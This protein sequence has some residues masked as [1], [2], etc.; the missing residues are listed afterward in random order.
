MFEF[1]EQH[2]KLILAL[3]IAVVLGMT[4]ILIFLTV[5][6]QPATN[7]TETVNE[8][9]YS[10][11]QEDISQQ[12]Q[13]LMLLGKIVTEGYGTYSK[14]DY[15]G[16]LDV[17]NQATEQF[18]ATVQQQ[19]NTMPATKNVSTVVDAE[20]IKLENT[21]SSSATVRMRGISTEAGKQQSITSTVNL[22][23]EGEYWLVDNITFAK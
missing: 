3:A 23:K 4:A 18:K 12:D 20:T 11:L 17:Q 15:R 5:R 13:Y 10:F 19:I 22:V 14:S 16:L 2:K 9:A 1:F 7:N 21:S 8:P 6:Q